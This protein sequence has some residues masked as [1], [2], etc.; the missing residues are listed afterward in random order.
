MNKIKIDPERIV[1]DID[2]NIFG[3]YLE[4]AE[5]IHDIDIVYSP[6]SPLADTDGLRSDVR[7]AL[8]RMR[9]SNIRY[10]GGNM[11]SGY[12]WMD[13][14]GPLEKRPIRHDLA[15]N[16]IEPNH[17]GTNEFIAFCRKLKAEP[18]ICVNCGDGGLREATDWVEYCN[19]IGDIAM[20]KLRREHGFDSPHNVKYWGIGNEVDAP[21]QI[22]YKTPQEYA[23]AFTEFGKVMKWVDQNI[24]L[25]A[26]A[27]SVWEDTPEVISGTLQ[28]PRPGF[29]SAIAG[30]IWES[31]WIERARLILEEAGNLVDYM[32]FHWYARP[33]D[34]DLFEST[35]TFAEK[36]EE[37]LSA[38]EGLIHAIC[39]ER[40][41][42]HPISIAVDEWGLIRRP[43]RRGRAFNLEDALISAMHL[44]AYIRH[45][46]SVRMANSTSS[47]ELVKVSPEHPDSIV[48]QT[49]FYPFEIYSHSCGQLALD[50]YWEGE[51]F[52]SDEYTGI[53]TLDVAA[54]L[55]SS[56]KQLTVY[57][58]NRS[59][60]E[61]METTISLTAGRFAENIQLFTVNGPDVK[62]ENT[63]DCPDQVVTRKTT[64]KATGTSL[65][66]SFEPHSVTVLVCAV[67]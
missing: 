16:V 25:V 2:R 13:G 36:F 62:S 9:I 27:V 37:H 19:G 11:S 61:N 1:S 55:D 7:T 57:V 8:E 49:I 21:F 30:N 47:F 32:A 56:R 46:S 34:D 65:T 48:L 29:T 18:C 24:K 4:L 3:G 22:G 43:R 64:L 51:T 54:T 41:I 38:Y 39:L 28:G 45:A 20:A 23:R 5:A 10:P 12:R 66:Y 42:K 40:R 53:R 33:H 52:S 14:I 63:F 26:S 31:R 44:N 35:M 17:F 60:S 6:D 67:S 58:V 50:V 15:W 59:R